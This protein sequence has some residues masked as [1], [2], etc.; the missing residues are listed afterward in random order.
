MATNNPEILPIC[1]ILNA[2]DA[3]VQVMYAPSDEEKECI[4]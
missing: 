4:L 3:N 2:P 1:A